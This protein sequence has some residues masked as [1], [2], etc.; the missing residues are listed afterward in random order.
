MFKE[1]ENFL[2]KA[3]SGAKIRLGILGG[4]FDPVHTVHV[5]LARAAYRQLGLDRVV[6]MPARQAALKTSAVS[7]SPRDRL[8]MLSLALESADFPHS[9]SEMEIRRSGISYSVDT[10]REILSAHPNCEIYWIIGSDHLAKMSQWREIEELCRLAKFACARR[11]GVGADFSDAPKFARIEPIDFEPME[12]SST[13]LRAALKNGQTR[14]LKLD[15]RVLEYILKHKLYDYG[16]SE[17][18]DSQE[19]GG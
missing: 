7:A 12:L 15:P 18:N 17:K 13:E 8:A 16:K 4:S 6:F 5:G 1:K 3:D 10:V 9:I 2:K 19:D 11:G 14:D